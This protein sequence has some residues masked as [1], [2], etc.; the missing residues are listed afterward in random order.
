[1]GGPFMARDARVERPCQCSFLHRGAEDPD[2]PI[3]F[4]TEPDECRIVFGPPEAPRSRYLSIGYCPCCGGEAPKVLEPER[5]VRITWDEM[6]RLHD[7]TK[8]IGTADEAIE[9]LG[10]PDREFPNRET[11]RNPGWGGFETITYRTL[12]W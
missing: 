9:R 6:K 7:L 3:E 11:M 1:M 8:G 2:V 12:H 4:H 10:P 5:F